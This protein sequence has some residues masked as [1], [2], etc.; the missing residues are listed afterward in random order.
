M[1]L[2]GV[3]PGI[4]DLPFDR[5]RAGER[6][7]D[8]VPS[9]IG[10][11]RDGQRVRVGRMGPGRRLAE[12]LFKVCGSMLVVRDVD[13]V[14]ARGESGD[15]VAPVRIGEG[16]AG[17][18][19]VSADGGDDHARDGAPRGLVG[20]AAGHRGGGRLRAN[21][22]GEHEDADAH[23]PWIVARLLYRPCRRGS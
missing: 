15:L 12:P 11:E 1:L 9:L 5:Q 23:H 4:E 6:H 10:R 19:I 18:A 22:A 16:F 3:A 7:V 8:A 17:R 2:K 14:G 21:Q 20:D 13:G